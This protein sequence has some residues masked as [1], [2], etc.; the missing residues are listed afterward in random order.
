MTFGE[1]HNTI[2]DMICDNYIDPTKEI[3][4]IFGREFALLFEDMSNHFY[5][6]VDHYWT[7]FDE[8]VK[9]FEK[10]KKQ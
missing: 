3:H 4:A 2:R 10:Y 1:F 9:D 7:K 8:F 5:D 6:E